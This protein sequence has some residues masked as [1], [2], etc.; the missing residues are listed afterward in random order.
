MKRERQK[1]IL[2]QKKTKSETKKI[3]LNNYQKREIQ[4]V[5]L[6]VR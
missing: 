4:M 5:R 6:T 3:S 1:H 2:K